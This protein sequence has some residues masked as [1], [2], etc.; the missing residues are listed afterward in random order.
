MQKNKNLIKNIAKTALPVTIQNI[1][2]SSLGIVDVIMIGSLGASAIAS[3]GIANKFYLIYY[4]TIF[5]LCSG[6]QIY[7]AQYWGD[8]NTEK[9]HKAMGANALP[10]L[11]LIAAF[12]IPSILFPKHIV[13]MFSSDLKIVNLGS[14]YL[15]IVAFTAP[16]FYI[17]QI[18]FC[19]Y[20]AIGKSTI[21]MIISTITLGL[22]TVLNYLLIYGNYGFPKLGVRGAA[23]ATLISSIVGFLIIVIL[24]I[25][26]K[27]PI[28][29]GLKG[30]FNFDF[31]FFKMI[32]VKSLPI[33]LNEMF[34][35]M[36]YALYGMAFSKMSAEAFSS[37][38]I[39]NI[40]QQLVFTMGIGLA[41]SNTVTLG[42][43]LGANQI[44]EALEAE[45]KITKITIIVSVVSACILYFG[46]DIINILFKV[47]PQVASNA[48]QM[49]R[50]GA[51]FLPLKFYTLV[52]IVGTMRAG[53]D[54]LASVTIDL[55]TM[56][57]IGV[58][59]AFFSLH[60][61]K[62]PIY[63][64]VAF[65]SSEEFLKAWLCHKRIKTKKWAK[66]LSKD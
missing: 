37:Y 66:N 17:A 21:P 52:Q 55:S 27:N 4:L 15:R 57:L 33:A 39:F 42:N 9:F 22:N 11:V 44:E 60:V 46:A 5:G 19:A 49:M 64:A 20:R 2:S 62:V 53:G 45:R 10:A 51:L 13:S 35:S 14:E 50:V 61:L 8:N 29:S 34:W 18:S 43:M 23:I 41:I 58:P 32:F 7:L 12:M 38:E 28:K 30:Y 56:F 63:L 1:I 31:R 65:I 48:K 24:I 16:L 54:S 40:T 36:G 25:V 47:D 6:A 3:A 59:L 26:S